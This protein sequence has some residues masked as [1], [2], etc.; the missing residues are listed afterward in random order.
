MEQGWGGG[1]VVI[2]ISNKLP[3]EEDAAG[4]KAIF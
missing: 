1:G 3:G 4:L 2:S